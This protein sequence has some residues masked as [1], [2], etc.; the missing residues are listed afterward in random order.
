M[1]IMM[2]FK[3]IIYTKEEGIAIITLNRPENMNALSSRMADEWVA[4]LEDAQG[5]EEVKVVVV[6]G[7]GRAFCSGANPRVLDISREEGTSLSLAEKFRKRPW[8][9]QKVGMAVAKLEKPYIG[10]INGPAIG[11]GMDLASMCDIRIAS[12]KAKFAMAYIRM[13]MVP[14]G[15]GCFLL[16]RIIGIARTCELIWTGRTIDAQ[17][18]LQIGYVSRVVPQEELVAVTR[19]LAT[20]L[21]KGP[22]IAIQL[23]KRLI[24][25]CLEMNFPQALEAHHVAGLIAESTEDAKEGPRA[26]VEKREPQFKGK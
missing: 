24:Y 8:V 12:E 18:A 22:A 23:A 9:T 26:W 16:P 25:S 19:E 10:S 11:G 21:A 5:D 4:A 14:G 15:G 13:G 7:A 3:D 17:E 2:N 20:Q 1:G 6:T